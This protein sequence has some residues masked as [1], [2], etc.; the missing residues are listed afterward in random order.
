MKSSFQI[1]VKQANSNASHI[2]QA[3]FNKRFFK[4]KHPIDSN[5]Y[6]ENI[7]FYL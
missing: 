4:H 2:I 6:C 7:L 3:Y 5:W 1:T